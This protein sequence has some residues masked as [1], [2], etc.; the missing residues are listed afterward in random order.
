MNGCAKEDLVASISL[1]TADC[2]SKSEPMI[3]STHF[4]DELNFSSFLTSSSSKSIK[5]NSVHSIDEQRMFFG[6]LSIIMELLFYVFRYGVCE[7]NIL[8]SRKI[9]Q[10]FLQGQ[11]DQYSSNER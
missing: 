4:C 1:C 7:R 6:D 8:D 11:A 10:A 5:I 2:S 9:V 3:S